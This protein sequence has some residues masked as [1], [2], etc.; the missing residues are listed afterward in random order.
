MSYSSRINITHT[1]SLVNPSTTFK[2]ILH[3][4]GNVLSINLKDSKIDV[5][6]PGNY[7]NPLSSDEYQRI[8]DLSFP[9]FLEPV[10][11][12][13][14]H[15]RL[16]SRRSLLTFRCRLHVAPWLRGCAISKNG[17]WRRIADKSAGSKQRNHRIRVPSRK[18][19]ARWTMIP[20]PL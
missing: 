11:S 8:P 19:V 15:A 18:I 13:F 6:V 2:W 12:R 16:P 14:L 7:L 5:R 9:V 20:C 3:T 17:R 1:F 4:T 10:V